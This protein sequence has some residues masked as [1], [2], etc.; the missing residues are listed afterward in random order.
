MNRA[1]EIRLRLYK[2]YAEFVSGV[3]RDL[4]PRIFQIKMRI[5]D[6]RAKLDEASIHR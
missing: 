3:K 2:V 1:S 6:M 5:K 4:S